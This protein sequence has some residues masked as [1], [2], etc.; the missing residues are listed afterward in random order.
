MEGELGDLFVNKID[1]AIESVA[2]LI[3]ALKANF[4]NFLDYLQDAENRGVRYKI[5]IGHESITN[6][7]IDKLSCPI[8]RKVRNI[9]IVP[10]LAGSGENWWMWVGAAAMFALA[11]FAPAGFTIWGT[12]GILASST[13]I[14]LGTI[15]LFAGISSLFKPAKPEPDPTSQTIGGLP[16]NTQEGGRVPVVYGKIQT[17]MYVISARVDSSINQNPLSIEIEGNPEYYADRSAGF[18]GNLKLYGVSIASSDKQSGSKLTFFLVSGNGD[19]YNNR[20][21]IPPNTNTLNF[22]GFL[23]GDTYNIPYNCSNN[24]QGTVVC[25][26]FYPNTNVNP[27]TI[28]VE[29]QVHVKE[30]INNYV[31]S[32][33]IEIP[34]KI[35]NLDT[36]S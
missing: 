9:R 34:W 32:Q 8:S 36:S 6:D 3:R 14:L 24:E 13:T 7:K 20:F 17:S 1:L 27:W 16:N 23:P 19:T 33:K 25:S 35:Y 4:S 30:N 26:N 10:I 11:I 29:A 5:I 2:E 18:F 12:K 31:F 21:T 28:R 22:N 15:L